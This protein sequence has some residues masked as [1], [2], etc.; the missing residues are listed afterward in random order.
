[1]EQVTFTPDEVE[2]YTPEIRTRV[3][4]LMNEIVSLMGEMDSLDQN[5]DEALN[6][7][8]VRC[9][10]ELKNE[11]G[12]MCATELH[13]Q[14]GPKERVTHEFIKESLKLHGWDEG[15]WYEYGWIF[16]HC[17]AHKDQAAQP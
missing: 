9:Q 6:I 17:P 4:A 16:S 5:I 11:L 2:G 8:T 12:D 10:G 14:K 15:T 3:A 7:Q 1:M 13:I